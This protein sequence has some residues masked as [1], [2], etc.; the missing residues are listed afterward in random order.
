MR[1]SLV[2]AS[3]ILAIATGDEIQSRKEQMRA[4][5]EAEYKH[6]QMFGMRDSTLMHRLKNKVGSLD[7]VQ[8]ALV[9]VGVAGVAAGGAYIALNL[10]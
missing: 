8:W 5:F 10:L 4:Y 9:G 6:Q 7:A 2:L 3:T 1:L